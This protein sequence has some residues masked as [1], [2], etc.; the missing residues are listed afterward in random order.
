[1]TSR[2][3]LQAEISVA[4]E[5]SLGGDDNADDFGLRITPYDYPTPKVGDILPNSYTWE[6]DERTDEE[7]NGVSTIGLESGIITALRHLLP[8]CGGYFG[9]VIVLVRGYRFGAGQDY[10]ETVIM[11]AEVVKVW[12]RKDYLGDDIIF[13]A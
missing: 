2:Q 10:G 7:L 6:E 9:K 8:S 1:M 4:M 3:R 11:D 5:A 13:V 12:H